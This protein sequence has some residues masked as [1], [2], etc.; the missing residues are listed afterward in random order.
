M[1]IYKLDT[2]N[3]IQ[4]NEQKRSAKKASIDEKQ[5][6]TQNN[7]ITGKITNNNK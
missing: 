5:K 1:D 6:K 3:C 4:E 7:D 2:K